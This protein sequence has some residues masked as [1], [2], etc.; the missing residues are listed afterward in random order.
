MTGPSF[1]RTLVRLSLYRHLRSCTDYAFSGIVAAGLISPG[2]KTRLTL[3]IQ[4]GVIA[5]SSRMTS[6]V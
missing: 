6:G 1:R 5:L 3:E 2:T 4:W